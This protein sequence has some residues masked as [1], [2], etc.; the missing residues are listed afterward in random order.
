MHIQL[1]RLEIGDID[2]D[3]ASWYDN[4][5][6]HL[7]YFTGSG[8]KFNR[9]D[10]VKDFEAGM[11]TGRWVY[12]LI[13]SERGDRIGN[14]KIGPIDT[15][16]KTAD[17][18]CLVGNRNFLGQGIGSKAIQIGNQIAFD[19]FDIRRLHSGM[20]ASNVASIKA[21][22]RAGW[23]VEATF[24]GYYWIDG[25]AE[26]RVCVACFNPKHFSQE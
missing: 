23:I 15:R 9:D 7:D 26:D 25:K 22:T 11:T 8:R 13:V 24:K 14:V 3:Y 10:L 1:R 5:D 16:N 20:Y 12:Y 6:G 2:D 18:V 19:E 17:L 21:Y 4:Q